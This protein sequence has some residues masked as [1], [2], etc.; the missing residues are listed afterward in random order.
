MG[1]GFI[2]LGTMGG[3]MAYNALDRHP[4]RGGGAIRDRV[5]LSAR[6]PR[7]WKPW[8]WAKRESWRA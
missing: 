8:L 2:G 7:K 3:N 1:I 5:Y 4:Q 6:P